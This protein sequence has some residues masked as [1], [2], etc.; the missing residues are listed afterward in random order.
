MKLIYC[1]VC[2]GTGIDPHDN[3]PMG[4]SMITR[5]PSCAGFGF[6][7]EYLKKAKEECVLAREVSILNACDA[8]WEKNGENR[9]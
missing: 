8:A 2:S 6:S 5:C 7:D 9:R 4:N 1:E 3:D